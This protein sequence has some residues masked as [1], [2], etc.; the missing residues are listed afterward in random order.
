[1]VAYREERRVTGSSRDPRT[2]RGSGRCHDPTM[3]RESAVAEVDV[4]VSIA[5][6]TEPG[7]AGWDSP[8]MAVPGVETSNRTCR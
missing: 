8:A 6:C 7:N 5:A 3:V 1:M 2:T 4:S